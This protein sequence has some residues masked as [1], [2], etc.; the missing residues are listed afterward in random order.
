M[1]TT[2]FTPGIIF[3]TQPRAHHLFPRKNSLNHNLVSNMIEA[4]FKLKEA[5]GLTLA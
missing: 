5:I 2:H 4:R 3:T 1:S